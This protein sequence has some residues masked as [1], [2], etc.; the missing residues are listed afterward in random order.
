MKKTI[1]VLFLFLVGLNIVFADE[2]GL[3]ESDNE[4]TI[5]SGLTKID[6][7]STTLTL[8]LD[9]DKYLVGFS[10]TENFTHQGSIALSSGSIDKNATTV[11]L[12]GKTFY[13]FYKAITDDPNVKFQIAVTPL[14]LDGTVVTDDSKKIDYTADITPE[15]VWNGGDVTTSHLDTSGTTVTNTC[16]L[17]GSGYTNKYFVTGIAKVVISSNANLGSKV[18]GAYSG[19]IT[20]TLQSEK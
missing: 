7:K 12:E 14:Y 3:V 8:S 11:S 9:K 4:S 17:K 5:E 13:F 18:P 2:S 19:T 6:N 10:E 15:D 20:V 1:I 16:N